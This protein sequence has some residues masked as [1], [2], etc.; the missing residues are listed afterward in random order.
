MRIGIPREIVPGENR[1]AATPTTVAA[2]RELEES[3][4]RGAFYRATEAAAS[5]AAEIGK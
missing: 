4:V 2:I 1:V 3:G 5:R